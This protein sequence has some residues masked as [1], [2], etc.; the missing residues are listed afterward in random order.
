MTDVDRKRDD[1]HFS[2]WTD[3]NIY[4]KIYHLYFYNHSF[5]HC[6]LY[7]LYI[8]LDS[9][10]L[11]ILAILE[12]FLLIHYAIEFHFFVNRNVEAASSLSNI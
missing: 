6:L 2:N 9:E 3:V 10:F 5:I 7:G 1:T 12:I 4:I 8:G 11:N